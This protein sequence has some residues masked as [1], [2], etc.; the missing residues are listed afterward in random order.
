MRK[1]MATGLEIRTPSQRRMGSL[2]G[3]RRGLPGAKQRCKCLRGRSAWE[4]W[5]GAR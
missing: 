3:L 4:G 5:S 1:R 2:W